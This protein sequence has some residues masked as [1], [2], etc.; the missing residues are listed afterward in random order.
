LGKF[1]WPKNGKCWYI[2]WSFA[3]FYAS[4]CILV[5]FGKVVAPNLVYFYRFGIL[6]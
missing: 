5:P 6:H 2:L 1:G 4:C 3:I